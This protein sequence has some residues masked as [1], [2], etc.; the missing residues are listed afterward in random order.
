[1]D[2]HNIF[3]GT[4]IVFTAFCVIGLFNVVTGIF[5]DSAVEASR[6]FRSSVE[7]IAEHKDQEKREKREEAYLRKLLSTSAG[8]HLTYREL[9]EHLDL[10]ETEAFWESHME[11]SAPKV[12]DIFLLYHRLIRSDESKPVL[13]LVDDENPKSPDVF[14]IPVKEFLAFT[15][16]CKGTASYVDL[17]TMMHDNTRLEKFI[18]NEFKQLKERLPGEAQK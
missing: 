3:F 6:S 14:K 5:V 16:K 9:E 2:E 15:R 13:P 4:F 7:V 12:K 11:L 10:D 1:M 8:N 17:L 18:H